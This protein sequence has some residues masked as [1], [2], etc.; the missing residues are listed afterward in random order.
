[1]KLGVYLPGRLNSERCPN[2]LILPIGDTCLWEIA[3]DKLNR[4]PSRFN[5]YVLCHEPQLIEIAEQY[6]S[7][8]VI[9]RDPE[10]IQ[11][12]GP[13]SYIFKE[14]KE[15]PETHLMFLNGCLS[16]LSLTTIEDALCKFEE[17][18][19]DYATSATTYQNWLWNGNH[20]SVTPIDYERLSTKEIPIHYQAAHCFHIFN[21][22]K[23]FE[24]GKM[25]TKDLNL[26]FVPKE[27]LLDVDTSSD[28]QYVKWVHENK[29]Q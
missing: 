10:T 13:L 16:M 6:N 5:R 12:D 2:K 28:Y 25:L 15:L 7:I 14:L 23:F 4:L 1:M 20:E 26:L 22:Q 24:D 17:A 18:N 27:E 9:K 11:V 29:L 21:K 8:I 19:M 3:C